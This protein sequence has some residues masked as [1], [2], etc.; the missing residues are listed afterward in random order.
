MPSTGDGPAYAH[1]GPSGNARWFIVVGGGVGLVLL[2]A[3][4][5]FA[6]DVLGVVFLLLFVGL[7]IRAASEWLSDGESASGWVLSALGLSLLGTALEGV[8][9]VGSRPT[10]NDEGWQS[11]LPAPVRSAIVWG[12]ERG[13]GQR[14]LASD[15]A[16]AARAATPAVAAIQ[17][18]STT[19]A[20][21]AA[22]SPPASAGVAPT[23]HGAE[24]SASVRGDEADAAPRSHRSP[25]DAAPTGSESVA[26]T[27]TGEPAPPAATTIR[28]I[29]SQGAAPVGTSLRL[30]ARIAAQPA[31]EVRPTGTAVFRRGDDVLGSAPVGSD[32]A[33][34]LS[35]LDLPVGTYDI[36]A[37]YLGDGH[38][39]PSRSDAL[40]QQI[41]R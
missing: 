2:A 29:S 25:S 39:L 41:V 24:V 16:P 31:A 9:L 20:P 10:G 22:P 11:Q 15:A 36:T 13:W 33:A 18:P 27:P 30:V 34:F 35:V 6:I 26:P 40:V 1:D 32:G 8:W 19:A 37:G 28:L 38:C 17:T 12:E 5:R 4:L 7:A 3:L 14:A 23:T 21:D